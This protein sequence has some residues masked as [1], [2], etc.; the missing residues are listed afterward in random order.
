MAE[1][2][3]IGVVTVTYNSAEVLPDFLRCM[4]G[5]THHNY[6][7][8]VVDNAS[9]DETPTLLA[10]CCDARVR[11]IANP[12]NLGV[13][14]GNNQG[15]NAAL[16]ANCDKVLLINNDTE[17]GEELITGLLN[18]LEHH[19]AD[20]CCPKIM[21]F[22]A[23]DR[24]WA[25]GGKFRPFLGFTTVHLGFR[26]TD[27]GQFNQDRPVDYVPT[28]SVLIRKRVFEKIGLMDP[29]YF[30]YVDDVDFMYR[31]RKC[32]IKLFYLANVILLHKAGFLT[33][34]EGSLFA[35][36]FNLRNRL[37]FLMKHF[38]IIRTLPWLLL[39]QAVWPIQTI[40]YRK[41]W[42]WFWT[43]QQAFLES[44]RMYRE[45]V[46]DRHRSLGSSQCGSQ[47]LL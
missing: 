17:F 16:E 42:K 32:G 25:A 9:K 37:Y 30:V 6:I 36:R 40:V 2:D 41:N 35:M 33:G 1:G 3:L 45:T 12:A 13:A 15:I 26:Q 5:Q 7:L 46:S 39:H 29:R 19:G 11:V 43:K 44:I 31:A 47:I 34:G 14:E 18:G 4:A 23:P 24:I 10:S 38:G 28:C 27:R 21:Y 22:D 20:M 8:F